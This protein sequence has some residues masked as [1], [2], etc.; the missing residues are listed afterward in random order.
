[1][2]GNLKKDLL[3]T[4]IISAREF[5]FIPSKEIDVTHTKCFK[6]VFLYFE[7]LRKQKIKVRLLNTSFQSTA[8]QLPIKI[9]LLEGVNM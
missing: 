4:H 8:S 6:I 3:N 2:V 9:Q 1:M 7:C 5:I